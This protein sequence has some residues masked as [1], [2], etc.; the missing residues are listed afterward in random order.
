MKPILSCVAIA[1]LLSG[2]LQFTQGPGGTSST[3][4]HAAPPSVAQVTMGEES[5]G[6]TMVKVDC[7]IAITGPDGQQSLLSKPTLLTRDGETATISI[8]QANG[9]TLTLEVLEQVITD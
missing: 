5:E 7:R 2:L 8:S 3:S 9:E 4:A 1:A 6:A